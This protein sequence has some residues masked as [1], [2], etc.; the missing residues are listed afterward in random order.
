MRKWDSI[1]H[2]NKNNREN[3]T[4]RFPWKKVKFPEVEKILRIK[5]IPEAL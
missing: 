4:P 5:P 1:P 3:K 2:K